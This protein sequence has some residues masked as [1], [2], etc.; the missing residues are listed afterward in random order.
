MPSCRQL[1]G[2]EIIQRSR[3]NHVLKLFRKQTRSLTEQL[4]HEVEDAWRIFFVDIF[5]KS[6]SETDRPTKGTEAET[7][8]R[9]LEY[10]KDSTWR[11]ECMKREEKF[12][13]QF[14]A[15]VS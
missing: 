8:V 7:W 6:L 12:D 14:K 3:E 9:V 1:T 5:S 4:I 10:V 2:R 13:M 15:L 11:S